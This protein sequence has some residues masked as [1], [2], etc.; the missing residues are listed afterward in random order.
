MARRGSRTTPTGGALEAD[1]SPLRPPTTNMPKLAVAS[2]VGTT[3]E[4]ADFG[5][6]A[7]ASVL[8]FPHVFF[9]AL[10]NAAGLT[11][12]LATFGVAF[13]AR[14]FGSILFG[15]YGDR[16]GR[17]GT[18]I[19]TLVIMGLST[20]LVGC[21]PP[22]SQIGVAAPVILIALRFAQ[23]LAVGG[24]WAGAVLTT[25]EYAPRQR[26]GFWSMFAS[27]GGGFGAI[28]SSALVAAGSLG[29]SDDNYR[30]WGW[31]LPFIASIVL[32]AVGLW[33]RTTIDETPVFKARVKEHGVSRVPFL[34]AVRAQP[35]QIVLASGM[36][37]MVYSSYY[38][39]ITFLTNYATT[40]LGIPRSTTLTVAL[41]AT[42]FYTLGILLTGAVADRFGRRRLM[43][44]AATGA[45]VY[46]LVMFPIVD[47]GTVAGLVVSMCGTMFITGCATGPLGAF[48]SE[49]F[50]TQY[51]YSAVGFCYN[52]AGILGGAV[53]PLFAAS[54]SASF[55]PS[56]YGVLVAVLSLISLLCV[57]GLKDA[58]NPEL[59]QFGDA[60]RVS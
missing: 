12:S 21:I 46:P 22:A 16:L 7:L 14:P 35:R 20:V 58:R 28:L 49:T 43:L 24:E 55:G 25:A 50:R 41:A 40:D 57:A 2:C 26:R 44:I 45:V 54:I 9:P 27:L 59:D 1:S 6:F 10:G 8:V 30:S 32:V 53:P 48:L 56:A 34:E 5:L 23:G 19:T 33:A 11:A 31:R 36:M 52:F 3:I 17:K 37:L 42:A 39:G 60:E 51:R 47:T 15:H 29:M 38:L 13:V 18:L 4:L